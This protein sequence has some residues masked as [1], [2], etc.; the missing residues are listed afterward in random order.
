MDGMTGRD[1]AEKVQAEKP[2]LKAIFT[3]GYSADIVGKDFII[4]AVSAVAPAPKVPL[5][6]LVAEGDPAECLIVASRDA[7]LLVV[8]TRGRSPFAGLL[9]GSVS[10]QCVHHASCPVEANGGRS[11]ISG[12]CG[13]I[14]ILLI[15]AYYREQSSLLHARVPHAWH[16][17][18]PRRFAAQPAGHSGARHRAVARDGRAAAGKARR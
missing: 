14:C 8:G 18:R 7:E 9:L 13:H 16:R 12:T 4:Q 2:G 11:G 1:L 17:H 6:T 15:Y 3:S 5:H 10:T